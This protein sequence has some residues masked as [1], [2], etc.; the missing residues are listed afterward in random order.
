MGTETLLSSDGESEVVK[1]IDNLRS[2]GAPVSA[3]MLQ[4]KALEIAAGGGL[5]KDG[6]KALWT[7]R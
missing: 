2:E 4:R 3:F 7:F 6:F 1:W 5:S